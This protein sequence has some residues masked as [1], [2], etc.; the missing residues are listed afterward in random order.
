MKQM[1]NETNDQCNVDV[2]NQLNKWPMKQM[3]NK[4]NKLEVRNKLSM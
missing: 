1:A 3:V 2:K 4:T